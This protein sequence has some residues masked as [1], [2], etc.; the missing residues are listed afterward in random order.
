MKQTFQVGQKYRNRQGEYEVISIE[1]SKMVIRYLKGGT[2]ET[3]VALQSRILENIQQEELSG[4]QSQKGPARPRS[5]RK[6]KK[7]TKKPAFQG[8]Q[9]HDFQKGVTGTSWRARTDLGGLLAREMSEITSQSFQ[10]YPIPRRPVVH[11]VRV[12]DYDEKSKWRKAKFMLE[13]SPEGAE[14]GFYIEKNSGAMDASWHWPAFLAAMKSATQLSQ[15]ITDAMRRLNLS[16]KIFESDATENESESDVGNLIA[17]VKAS[18]TGLIWETEDER[19]QEEIDWPTFVQ[20]LHDLD[21]EKWHD[22]YLVAR[23]PKKQAI[24]TGIHFVGE[25]TKVYRA[26]LPLYDASTARPL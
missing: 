10:S 21:A 19:D 8:L 2:I 11:V 1:G 7:A 4:Q 13:L 15:K 6:R 9:D 16:W 24:D 23:M 22:L 17:K 26:L 12:D 20:Q 18:P 5:G 3:T 14:Y 25:V